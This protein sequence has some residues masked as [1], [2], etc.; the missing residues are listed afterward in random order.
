MVR[1]I[2]ARDHDL[3]ATGKRDIDRRTPRRIGRLDGL[4]HV[5]GLVAAVL[6]GPERPTPSVS[7]GILRAHLGRQLL[8]R[9][10]TEC[11]VQV[12]RGDAV[13]RLRQGGDDA[14]G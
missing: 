7:A 13:S 10:A 11:G 2:W 8:E 12:D 3:A 9:L 1:R 6:A 4:G 14:S 5:V